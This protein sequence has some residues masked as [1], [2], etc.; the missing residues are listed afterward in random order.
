M[1][2][3]YYCFAFTYRFP[4]TGSGPARRARMT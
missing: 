1:Q 2:L 4:Y 3:F